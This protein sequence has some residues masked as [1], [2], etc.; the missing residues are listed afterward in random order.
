MASKIIIYTL[1]SLSF[2]TETVFFTP[3][4]LISP[5]N[6]NNQHNLGF[7]IDIGGSNENPVALAAWVNTDR[8]DPN[9]FQALFSINRTLDNTKWD[10]ASCILKE[11]QMIVDSEQ[12]DN[13][14]VIAVSTAFNGISEPRGIAAGIFVHNRAMRT[15][16]IQSLGILST[17]ILQSFHEDTNKFSR[18][19]INPRIFIS[20]QFIGSTSFALNESGDNLV[21]QNIHANTTTNSLNFWKEKINTGSGDN[22]RAKCINIA[23]SKNPRKNLSVPVG[24]MIWKHEPAIRIDLPGQDFPL[25]LG[26]KT[27]RTDA[28]RFI[29]GK[30]DSKDK[31]VRLSSALDPDVVDDRS[32]QVAANN[33]GNAIASWSRKTTDSGLHDI[34][35]V[36]TQSQTDVFGKTTTNP[37]ST[38]QQVNIESSIKEG[39]PKIAFRQNNFGGLFSFFFQREGEPIEIHTTPFT[40]DQNSDIILSSEVTIASNLIAPDALNTSMDDNGNAIVLWRDAFESDRAIFYAVYVADVDQ[41]MTPQCIPLIHN[42]NNFAPRLKMHP[43]GNVVFIFADSN[44]N[45]KDYNAY[46]TFNR[47]MPITMNDIIPTLKETPSQRIQFINRFPTQG[48]LVSII[49]WKKPEEFNC[50][51]VICKNNMDIATLTINQTTYIDHNSSS[52]DIYTVKLINEWCNIIRWKPIFQSL[53]PPGHTLVGYN[54][55]KDGKRI[56]GAKSTFTDGSPDTTTTKYIDCIGTDQNPHTYIV[57]GLIRIVSQNMHYETYPS[58]GK[59]SVVQPIVSCPK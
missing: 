18:E 58:T 33:C 54:I 3:T 2:F 17:N 8:D 19:V 32:Q 35:Y 12:G 56:T 52:Q 40:I 47:F 6:E 46:S 7:D 51:F 30:W 28:L 24:F 41:W 14:D 15:I 23:L 42:T 45:G 50:G 5:I 48:D 55:Y 36:F 37:W 53:L 49:D 57:V 44:N 10:P 39:T 29:N 31:Q 4:Q 34:Y 43:N 1:T 9:P 13:Q 25:T 26:F 21:G 20:N 27:G 59:L 38:E 11:S 22:D 16:A